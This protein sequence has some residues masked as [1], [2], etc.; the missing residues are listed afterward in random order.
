MYNRMFE[1]KEDGFPVVVYRD[2]LKMTQITEM[3]TYTY[4]QEN[5]NVH[6]QVNSNSLFKNKRHG[7]V[8]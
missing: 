2:Y 5:V 6:I 3:S 7:R 8:R 4:I 1:W